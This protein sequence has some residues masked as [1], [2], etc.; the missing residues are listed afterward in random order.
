VVDESGNVLSL[1][2]SINTVLWG[3]SGIFVDGISI[4]DPASFQQAKIAEAGPGGR[5]A[6]STNPLLVLKSGKPVLASMAIGAALHAATLHNVINVLEFGLEPQSSVDQ[7]S[8]RGPPLGRPKKGRLT[9]D[10]SKEVVGRGD[11]SPEVI[12]GVQS[13]GQALEIVTDSAQLGYW[14]GIQI[15]PETGKLRGG[16]SR[17]LNGIAEGY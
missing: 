11:F 8:P 12:A 17:Q 9:F 3:A 10:R 7:P 2:H 13:K 4:P 16:V 15:E 6:E 14:I 5:L 1:L